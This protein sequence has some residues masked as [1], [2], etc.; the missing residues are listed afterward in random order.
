MQKKPRKARL[1]GQTGF[2]LVEITIVLVI[3][4]LLL[5]GVFKGQELIGSA[6]VKNLAQDFRMAQIYIHAYQDKFRALPGDDIR[7]QTRLCPAANPTCTTSGD[8]DGIING[9]WDDDTDTLSEAVRFWQHIRFANLASGSTDIAS[10]NFLPLNSEGGRIGIQSGGTEAPLSISGSY[11]MCSGGIPGKYIRQ[12]DD[13]LDDGN[14]ATGALRAGVTDA[15]SGIAL[16]DIV[17]GTAYVV[18]LGI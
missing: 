13:A 2:T 17:D 11:V 12:L 1:A 9:R 6:K 10:D 14:P 18:C 4:G 7:A 16:E 5:G 3:I 8:A 15:G